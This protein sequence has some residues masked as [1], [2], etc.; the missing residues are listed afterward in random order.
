[1][2]LAE[3]H[4]KNGLSGAAEAK[5][6]INKS[7]SVST[8]NTYSNAF[9]LF[10][11][12]L[13]SYSHSSLANSLPVHADSIASFITY[14]FSLDY[15]PSS[16]LTY[17]SAI[18]FIHKVG[19]WP[20]PAN[21]FIV[22]KMILGI[23]KERGKPDCR[24]PILPSFL[25]KL[26]F[27]VNSVV[28]SNFTRN[29]FKATFLLAFHAFLRVGEITM[30]ASGSDNL[31]KY[32]DMK[33]KTKT[34]E[35]QFRNYK[36]SHGQHPRLM[37]INSQRD[38][39]LCP[40]KA[41]REYVKYRGQE[42]GPLFVTDAGKPLSRAHFSA[43]FKSCLNMLHVD[44]SEYNTH[45]FRIG[46]ASWAAIKGMSDSQIREMGRWRSDAYRKYIRIG[47]MMLSQS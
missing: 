45:S 11:K 31:L 14:M 32:S 37:I 30:S 43:V 38:R 41:I 20:D 1:M 42:D 13:G 6:L 12:F 22:Q 34:I 9:K 26:V 7:L 36:H 23:Q 44:V 16:I 25:K 4:S 17:V 24:K 46:A 3:G 33:L 18:S 10:N 29:L 47:T 15:A 2:A 40:V 21:S 19:N 27:S 28:S 8:R 5:Y 35:L 39:S